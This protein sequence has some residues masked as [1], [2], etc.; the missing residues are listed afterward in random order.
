VPTVQESGFPGFELYTWT[1][2]LAPAH[3]PPEV[4][5]KLNKTIRQVLKE[6][7]VQ[8]KFRNISVD[9]IAT[10]EADLEKRIADTVVEFTAAARKAN[11]S[12]Q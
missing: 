3:T 4:V 1:A 5:A 8:T 7:D 2:F 9:P 12:S 6:P 10:T 11:I